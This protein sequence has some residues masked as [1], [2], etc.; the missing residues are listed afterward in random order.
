MRRVNVPGN[1]PH[2]PSVDYR[3]VGNF[4]EV[5]IFATHDQ[6]AKIRTAKHLEIFTPCVL[7]TSLAR[8]DV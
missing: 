6:N 5:Q 8:S 4:R 7:C 2:L 3:I 1:L